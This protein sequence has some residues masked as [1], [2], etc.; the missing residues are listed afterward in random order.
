MDKASGHC[1][2][3][4][5]RYTF[6][7]KAVLWRGLCH[8]DSCRRACSAP[9]VAWFGV[10]KSGWHWQGAAPKRR[11]S[12]DCATRYFCPAC[13]S[14]MAF[15][16]TKLPDEIHGLAPSLDDPAHFAPQAH[17]FHAE[18]MPWLHVT[19]DLPRYRDGGKTLEQQT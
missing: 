18:A 11:Q 7:T 4:A 9:V 12:S 16:T 13:G 10:Q 1:M 14:Q 19:D 2:C 15:E 17:F 5:V 3:G 8:C 6:D